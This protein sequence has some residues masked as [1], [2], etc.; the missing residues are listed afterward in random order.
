LKDHKGN[1]DNKVDENLKHNA[2]SLLNWK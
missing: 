2:L 1:G